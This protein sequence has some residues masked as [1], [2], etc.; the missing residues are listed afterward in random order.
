MLLTD[1]KKCGRRA[2]TLVQ[3]QYSSR[4]Y[5]SIH[6]GGQED[7]TQQRNRNISNIT[8]VYCRLRLL[9]KHDTADMLPFKNIVTTWVPLYKCAS[10]LTIFEEPNA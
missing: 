1:T 8:L 2:V 4:H 5:N 3:S 7:S 10:K 6:Y 9:Q